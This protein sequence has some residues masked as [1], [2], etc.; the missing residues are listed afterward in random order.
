[1]NVGREESGVDSMSDGMRGTRRGGSRVSDKRD[2]D[3]L[4]PRTSSRSGLHL[5]SPSRKIKT[6]GLKVLKDARVE[7]VDKSWRYG[8][9]SV[10]RYGVTRYRGR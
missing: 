4:C 9:L 6:T 5:P 3:I 1:M 2:V 7:L 10:K 8:G